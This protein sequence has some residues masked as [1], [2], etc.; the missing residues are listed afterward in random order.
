MEDPFKC[1]SNRAGTGSSEALK[2]AAGMTT[3]GSVLNLLKTLKIK[4]FRA[5]KLNA[6]VAVL[7]P[8]D[9]AILLLGDALLRG[10]AGGSSPIRDDRKKA[11]YIRLHACNIQIPK[12]RNRPLNVRIFIEVYLLGRAL[13]AFIPDR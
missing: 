1:L 6:N 8:F 11:N 10:R 12:P 2:G 4:G 13:I 9:T 3:P 5:S 7:A